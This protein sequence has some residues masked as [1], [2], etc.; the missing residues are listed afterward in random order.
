MKDLEVND[1]DISKLFTWGGRIQLQDRG[2]DVQAEVFVRL[3]GDAEI[4]RARVYALRRSAEMRK[5][6]RLEDSDERV[7]FIPEIDMLEKEQIVGGLINDKIKL[8]YQKIDGEVK[9]PAPKE[10]K[11]D[12]TLEQQEEYQKAVDSYP[13]RRQEKIREILETMVEDERNRLLALEKEVLFTEFERVTVNSICENVMVQ[14]FRD[15]CAFFGTFNNKEFT[16]RT[17]EEIVEF[18]N[19]PREVKDQLVSFYLALEIDG[20]ELKKLLEATQ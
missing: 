1:I 8:L 9:V 6:L 13:Q 15:M 5:R 4:N 12:A 10:L 14:T 11:S 16:E 3:L 2:G 19:F 20:A 7:A 17:F 18:D